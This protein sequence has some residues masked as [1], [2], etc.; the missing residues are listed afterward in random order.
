MVLGFGEGSITLQLNKTNFSFGETI[1][2]ILLLK[3]KKA[4]QARQL[5][6]SIVAEQVV[7]QYGGGALGPQVSQRR[8]GISTRSSIGGVS[9]ASESQVLF[10]TDVI[11]DGEKLYSPP[12][13]DYNFKIQVPAKNALPAQAEVPE[14]MLG[15]A[16]KATQFMSGKTQQV[17]WHIIA[18]LDVPKA[19]DISKKM[20]ISVQ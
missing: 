1:E 8:H 15:T 3:L 13:Q 10:S 4:K 7:T 5:V 2:G 9:K 14:G 17:K 20:Q 18:K 12:G 11:V 19:R 6:V 16:L